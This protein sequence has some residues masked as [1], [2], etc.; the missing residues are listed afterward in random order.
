MRDDIKEYFQS[1]IDNIEI[2]PISQ[3]VFNRGKRRN[4]PEIVKLLSCIAATFIVLLSPLNRTSSIREIEITEQTENI[5][6]EELTAGL[7]GGMKYFS[8]KRRKYE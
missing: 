2:P 4:I 7:L 8:E 6:K 3:E 5:I 1:E